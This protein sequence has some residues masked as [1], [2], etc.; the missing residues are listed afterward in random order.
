MGLECVSSDSELTRGV[1]CWKYVIHCIRCKWTR[2]AKG[3]LLV[4]KFIIWL[5][6]V[7]AE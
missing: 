5:L 1:F 6:I 3:S 2:E 4:N 7:V